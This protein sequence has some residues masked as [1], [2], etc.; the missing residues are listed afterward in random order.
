M[1]WKIFKG[2]NPFAGGESRFFEI[3]SRQSSKSLD[4]LE[5]L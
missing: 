1:V 3:L 4:G 2:R 5:A